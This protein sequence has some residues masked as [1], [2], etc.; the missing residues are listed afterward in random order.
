MPVKSVLLT[1]VYFTVRLQTWPVY[2]HGPWLIE[3]LLGFSN[4]SRAEGVVCPIPWSEGV[5]CQIPWSERV[6][7]VDQLAI[8][9]TLENGAEHIQGFIIREKDIRLFMYT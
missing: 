5:L 4:Q 9:P 8:G 2:K 3:L 6:I 1:L 7:G